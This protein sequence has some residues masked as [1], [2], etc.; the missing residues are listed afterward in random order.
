MGLLIWI[1]HCWHESEVAIIDGKWRQTFPG[2]RGGPI[3]K[4]VIRSE[5]EY[6]TYRKECTQWGDL[7]R[8]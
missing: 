5:L 6:F 8:I 4:I 1:T 3:V 2:I 7:P